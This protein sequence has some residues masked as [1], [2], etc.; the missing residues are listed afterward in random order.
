M[1]RY[2]GRRDQLY[3]L[4]DTLREQIQAY[5]KAATAYWLSPQ[6][7]ASAL[8]AE[9]DL[10]FLAKDIGVLMQLMS[11]MGVQGLWGNPE[12]AGVGAVSDL[13]AATTSHERIART[14]KPDPSR[15]AAINDCAVHLTSLI[16]QKRWEVLKGQ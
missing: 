13:V 3:K 14:R 1:E 10:D 9:I 12:A 5:Q 6:T 2:R 16:L 4:T 11:A 7:S 8:K 15:V